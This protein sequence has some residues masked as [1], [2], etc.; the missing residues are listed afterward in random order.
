MDLLGA[1]VGRYVWINAFSRIN[2]DKRVS[3]DLI[4]VYDYTEL[5][6]KVLSIWLGLLVKCQHNSSSNVE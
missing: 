4:V 5:E 1:A 2:K 3:L 6:A